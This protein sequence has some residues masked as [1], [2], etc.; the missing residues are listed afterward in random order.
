MN[1]LANL[2]RE[3][4]DRKEHSSKAHKDGREGTGVLTLDRH[5]MEF[6]AMLNEMGERLD[7]VLHLGTEIA[8][9]EALA[10]LVNSRLNELRVRAQSGGLL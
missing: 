5:G 10:D 9:W 3:Y 6:L 2:L 1:R 4:I 7:S 8:L